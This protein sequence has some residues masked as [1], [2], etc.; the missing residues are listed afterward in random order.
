MALGEIAAILLLK[1]FAPAEILFGAA[2]LVIRFIAEYGNL[3][4]RGRTAGG[5]V[6]PSGLARFTMIRPSPTTA[7]A[8]RVRCRAVVLPILSMDGLRRV[9]C[10]YWGA[11]REFSWGTA[12]GHGARRRAFFGQGWISGCD[13]SRSRRWGWLS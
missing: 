13:R 8:I 11:A 5:S 1:F 3:A 2:A 9:R 12:G 7:R 6:V 4:E 10:D